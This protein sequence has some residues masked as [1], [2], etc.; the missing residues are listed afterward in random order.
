LSDE[1]ISRKSRDR[2]RRA[3]PEDIAIARRVR[4]LRLERGLS[5]NALARQ[6]GVSFQQFQKYEKGDNRISAG[7]LQRIALALHVP[8]TVFYGNARSGVDEASF[9]YL[10]TRGAMRLVRAYAGIPAPRSRTALVAL[11]E[12]LARDGGADLSP[13]ASRRT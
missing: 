13:P 12:A 1:A 5:Q 4:T 10:R 9:A 7:R 11:A 8:I 2:V 3:S 6:T